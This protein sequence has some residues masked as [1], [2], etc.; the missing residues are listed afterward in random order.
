MSVDANKVL[1][2]RFFHEQ[3]RLHGG[4]AEQLCASTYTAYIGADP[5]VDRA[6]HQQVA[7][8]LYAGFPDLHQAI[9]EILAEEDT[10]VVR[11]TL[12]GTHTGSFNG[13]P[14][15][16]RSIAVPVIA[17]LHVEGGRIAELR[18]V[19]DRVGLMRQLGVA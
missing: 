10:V 5:P 3:D 1:G 9:D 4:L 13:I 6:G 19:A 11:F 8:A 7:Q 16:G 18:A 2:R 15:T 14:A 17:I 12:R